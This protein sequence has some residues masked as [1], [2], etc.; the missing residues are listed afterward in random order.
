[1]KRNNLR[2]H[3]KQDFTGSIVQQEQAGSWQ[4]EYHY[5][6]PF[7]KCSLGERL[8]I[9]LYPAGRTT[10]RWDYALTCTHS[11]LSWR[12][13][14]ASPTGLVY[15]KP[16]LLQQHACMDLLCFPSKIGQLMIC[17]RLMEALE[18]A[19]GF[20]RVHWHITL[21][22]SVELQQRSSTSVKLVDQVHGRLMGGLNSI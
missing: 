12:L 16:S 7:Q 11:W 18:D 14:V 5:F 9:L 20:R 15:V 8:T 2:R 17:H 3:F 4:A 13:I 1:M 19:S 21:H 22:E 10:W 6:A